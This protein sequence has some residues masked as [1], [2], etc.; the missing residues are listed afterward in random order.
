LAEV[1]RV[2]SGGV[3]QA[4][5]ALTDAD[6]P[7]L[8]EHPAVVVEDADRGVDE[9]SLFHLYNHLRESGRFLV[10]TCRQVPARWPVQ[11]P[12][13]LSRLVTVPVAA[14]G[15][16][17]DRL[18]EAL[19]LKLFADR[20]LRIG[21]EVLAY[22]LPRMERSFDAARTLV[23]ALDAAALTEKRAITIPLVRDVLAAKKP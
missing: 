2:R 1:F 18:L 14:I 19:L 6:V 13:L 3:V 11:L 16:P 8:A 23:Q 20:Q 22:L 15:A 9:A 10:L 12:D 7:R 17:D 5:A 4:A 21:P